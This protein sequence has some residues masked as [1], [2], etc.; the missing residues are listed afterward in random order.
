MGTL[1]RTLQRKG[2]VGGVGEHT[3]GS[4]IVTLAPIRALFEA[5]PRSRMRGIREASPDPESLKVLAPATR[6][7]LRRLAERS[8]ETLGAP[9]T[10]RFV[11]DE[12]LR[13]FSVLS[14]AIA[15][16]DPDREGRLA[17]LIEAAR[18]AYDGAE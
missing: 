1:L 12:M 4:F 11:H 8:L 16:N 17:S 18:D 15:A 14:V 6:T 2:V 5:V 9:R 13:E 7:A 10:D 3:T